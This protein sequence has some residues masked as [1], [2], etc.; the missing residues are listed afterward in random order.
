MGVPAALM[1]RLLAAVAFE[2]CPLR[3]TD[4][5]AAAAGTRVSL[6]LW[7]SKKGDGPLHDGQKRAI[8]G[9]ITL[10]AKPHTA[11]GSLSSV[12]LSSV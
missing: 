8:H 7:F 9:G 3:R 12:A 6:S 5:M 4:L 1:S 10:L 2:R 11:L